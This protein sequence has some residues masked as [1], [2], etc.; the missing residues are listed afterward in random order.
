M[1]PRTSLGTF[2]NDVRLMEMDWKDEMGFG[3]GFFA[4]LIVDR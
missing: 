3:F 4:T 2:C 1:C